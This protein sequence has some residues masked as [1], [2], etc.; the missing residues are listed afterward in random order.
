MLT[1]VGT[2][3]KA[4][5]A[6]TATQ[7]ITGVGFQPQ[8]VLLMATRLTATGWNNTNATHHLVFGCS[9]GT[10]EWSRGVTV[11]DNSSTPRTSTTQTHVKALALYSDGLTPSL[12]AEADLTITSNGFD[13]SWTTNNS[14]AWQI[15]YLCIGGTNV[16]AAVGFLDTTGVTGN[17]SVTGLSFTP[18]LAMLS[19]STAG[20]IGT[21]T[22]SGTGA[23]F[24]FG[25]YDGT[26]QGVISG[27]ATNA[28]TANARKGQNTTAMLQ[29]HNTGDPRTLT[30]VAAGTSLNSDGFT[31][32][33]SVAQ[34]NR[35]GYI[36]LGGSGVSAKVVADVTKTSTGTQTT[37]GVGFQ[38]K[39]LLA[40]SWGRTASAALDF[41]PSWSFG[42]TDG[43][44]HHVSACMDISTAPTQTSNNHMTTKALG[45]SFSGDNTATWIEA[46][47]SSFDTDGYTLNYTKV[48][49]A[50]E[51]FVAVALGGSEPGGGGKA[52]GGKG[53]G[54]NTP[55]PGQP[56]KKALR[57]T[58]AGGW[59]WEGRGWR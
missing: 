39:A 35:V 58:I 3:S 50:T 42:L 18:K 46:E 44:S 25:A 11:V 8:L 1:K 19:H 17:R 41:D 28:G 51:Q 54:G 53:K 5:G 29:S 9:D 52:G 12:L 2:F 40:F 34:V 22:T 15:G 23:N 16:N 47:Y 33:V 56:P 7:S 36:A 45:L 24:S 49:A 30:L 55:G 13:L 38:P 4:T 26:T 14:E 32:N 48:S 10:N 31:V 27:G 59:R 6:A 57:G 20:I 43:T 21:S 37:T